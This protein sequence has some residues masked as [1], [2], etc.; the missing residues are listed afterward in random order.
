MS[1]PVIIVGAGDFGRE[2]YHWYSLDQPKDK[3]L[4]F[5]DDNPQ[6]L[7]N[8]Q[9]PV[10]ILGS[11]RD[12]VVN[13]AATYLMAIAEP[14]AKLKV[15]E[16][17]LERGADFGQYIHRTAMISVQVTLGTGVI[18]C[19]FGVVSCNAVVNDFVAVNLHSTVGH[20]V[21]IGAGCTLSSHVD[22]CGYSKI[23][24]G[25]FFGSHASVLPKVTIGDYSRVGA[26]S[27]VMT[28]VKEGMTV[29]GVPAKRI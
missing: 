10:G 28:R 21:Q 15:G 27:V 6:A 20:D 1:K 16:L 24:R 17:L 26:G 8:F 14:A 25:V 18:I 23:G 19:P 13:K 9:L 12:H 29:F 3:V 5:I 7:M 22:L 2:L 4:G 11:I